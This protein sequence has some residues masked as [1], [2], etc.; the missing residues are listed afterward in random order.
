MALSGI[1]R[2]FKHRSDE[3]REHATQLMFYQNVRGGRILLGDI[4][5]SGSNT[6]PLMSW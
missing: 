6:C 4:K 5:V 1:H 2:Y 3:E